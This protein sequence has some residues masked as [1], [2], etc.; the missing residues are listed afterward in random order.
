M[1]DFMED[2]EDSPLGDRLMDPLEKSVFDTRKDFLP[3]GCL[4]KIVS[5]KAIQFELFGK[6]DVLHPDEESLVNFIDRRAKKVFATAYVALGSGGH[7]LLVTMSYFR[8]LNFI[9]ESLPMKNFRNESKRNTQAEVPYPFNRDQG[10]SFLRIWPKLKVRNFYQTQWMFLAPV[11][12]KDYH[13]HILSIDIVLPFVWVN[14]V[15]K[16]G[17]FSKVYE[18]EIHES[19]QERKENDAITHVAIKEILTT[20]NDPELKQDIE[21]SF[22]LEADALSDISSLEHDHMIR[23][24]AAITIDTRHYFMFE[25]ADGGNL[26][27]FWKE[28]ALPDLTPQL[29]RQSVIQ[30]RGLA[31]ALES[32]HHYKKDAHY[33]HGDLKPENILRFKDETFVGRLKIA[34][35]GLAKRHTEVTDARLVATSTKYGTTRYEPPEATTNQL[36]ARSRLYDVWSLGCITLEYIIWLLYGYDGVQQFNDDIHNGTGCFYLIEKGG[37]QKKAVVHPT[38]VEWMND[39]SRHQECSTQT[40]IRSLLE[41]VRDRLLV[42]ALQTGQE[43]NSHLSPSMF[44]FTPADSTEAPIIGS[45]RAKAATVYS[46]LQDILDLGEGNQSYLLAN[47]RRDGSR[48]QSVAAIPRSHEFLQLPSPS[49]PTTNDTRRAGQINDNDDWLKDCDENAAHDNCRCGESPPLPTRLLDVSDSK[50]RLIET[51]DSHGKYLA[52]SHPWGD[53]KKHSHFCTYTGNIEKYKKGID[54]DALPNTFQDA[55]TLT[56]QLSVQYLWIDSLCIIQGS[57]G[58][59]AEQS[60]SME[61]VFSSAYCVI[62]ASRATGQGDGF[63]GERRQRDYVTFDHGGDTYHICEEIDDFQGDVI[64]GPLNQRGW[65][66]QERALARRTVYFTEKQTYWECGRGIRCETFTRLK[67]PFAIA[68]LEKR[69]IQGFGAH[70]GYGVLD[71]GKGLLHRS[72]LW[73]RPSKET[74]EK[75]NFPIEKKIFVPTWSWMAYQGGIDYLDPEWSKTDWEQRDL[76]SPWSAHS[77]FQY[78]TDKN[79][80]I[81]LEATARNFDSVESLK[82][83]IV[84]YFDMPDRA[85]C[86]IPGLKCVILARP[87]AGSTTTDRVCYVLLVAPQTNQ[88]SGNP[89]V[90]ERVGVGK[91]PESCISQSEKIDVRLQ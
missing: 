70:G 26:R 13:H 4:Q 40:A 44:T 12:S 58:D 79:S 76:R 31:D 3:E 57:D 77:P 25:W 72:L 54:F 42:V 61:D 45:F 39:L 88:N 50:I 90:F 43:T 69:L 22:T 6:K 46:A 67:K 53:P 86:S 29:I 34:D 62:A 47:E 89:A 28:Y 91:M 33:R 73:H 17:R 83:K 80:T 37:D 87:K 78:T 30:L 56:R 81:S 21:K 15:I 35:M 9:D 20:D 63:L 60:K 10:K 84:L 75:I 65:V 16:G 82:E 32:L 23:R 55:V 2:S 64:D 24:I 68:G 52:L 11:F 49:R 85:G 38:V 14:H 71:D 51:Q 41:L 36:K 18:V 66:L 59:F 74:L 1:G 5:R 8:S 7:S 27:E 19:H 48:R